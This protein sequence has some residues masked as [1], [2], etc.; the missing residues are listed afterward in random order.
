M[1]LDCYGVRKGDCAVC[2]AGSTSPELGNG[3][4]D[5]PPKKRMA[6]A[7]ALKGQ[8]AVAIGGLKDEGVIDHGVV[9]R[10]A[11]FRK[12]SRGAANRMCQRRASNEHLQ[13]GS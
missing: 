11:R 10:A 8:I 3:P 12:A 13:H 1:L 2:A 5:I 4:T 9:F 7:E 6:I